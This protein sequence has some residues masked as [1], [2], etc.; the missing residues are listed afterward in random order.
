MHQVD[1]AGDRLDLVHHV[2]QVQP[3]R[4]GVAGI[5]AEAHLAASAVGPGRHRVPEPPD[6]V[7]RPRHRVGAARRVLDQQRDRALD[8]FHDLA[9]VREPLRGIHPIRHVA[10]VDD[11]RLGADRRGRFELLAQDL[12]ARDPD[13][14]VG[15]RHVDHVRRVYIEVN[16]GRAE[17]PADLRGITGQD[18]RLPALGVTEEGLNRVRLAGDRL[19]QR[20]PAVDVDTDTHHPPSLAPGMVGLSAE[21]QKPPW[22]RPRQAPTNPAMIPVMITI[23]SGR[24]E[25][26]ICT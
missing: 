5:E 16:P 19:G 11:Q 8:P 17:G 18:R 9:P 25:E 20:V 23:R 7:Q 4:V 13:P 12:P 2:G 22:A 1:T 14:V 26:I 10:A 24:V 21:C 15:R 6:R 3:G